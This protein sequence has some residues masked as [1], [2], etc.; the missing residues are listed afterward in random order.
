M[1]KVK[2]LLQKEALC[3]LYNSLFQPYLTYCTEVWANTYKTKLKA[4]SVIQKK[5][6]RVVCK[7]SNRSHTNELFKE[8]NIL[9]FLD[10]LEYKCGIIMYNAYHGSLPKKLQHL[11]ELGNEKSKYKTRQEQHFKVNYR[12]TNVKAH[13]ISSYGVKLWNQLPKNIVKAKSLF[14]FKRLFKKDLLSRY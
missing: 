5:A 1:Y 12:R 6:I 4:I 13:C 9:K 7:V 11:F 14:M 8:L 3:M 2:F 10:L